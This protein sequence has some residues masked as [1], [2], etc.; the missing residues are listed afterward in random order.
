MSHGIMPWLVRKI[1]QRKWL[2]PEGLPED[3]VGADAITG[4]LRTGQNRLSLWTCDDPGNDAQI[5]EIAIALGT[6]LD[7][8]DPIDLAWVESEQLER[9]GIELEKTPGDTLLADMAEHHVDL[10]RVDQACLSVVASVFAHAIKHEQRYKRIGAK[11]LC[12]LLA[13]A[14]GTGRF[15]LA[16]LTEKQ[17]SLRAELSKH[18]SSHLPEK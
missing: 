3:A 2:N 10:I 5:N 13:T 11:K 6:R 16:Q 4:D 17:E 9:A 8:A 14:V 1:A 18:F 7:R 12:N 15:S